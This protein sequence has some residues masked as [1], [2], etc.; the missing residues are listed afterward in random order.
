MTGAMGTKEKAFH[1][2]GSGAS[3]LNYSDGWKNPEPTGCMAHF[4]RVP[5]SSVPVFIYNI[6]N[7][8]E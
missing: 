2:P 3:I 4:R 7:T 1:S 6:I 5:V 8:N